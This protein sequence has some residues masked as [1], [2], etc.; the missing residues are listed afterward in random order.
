[1][2]EGLDNNDVLMYSTLNEGKLLIA[3]NYKKNSKSIQKCLSPI[4]WQK[5]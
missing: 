5:T 2:Q 3:E 1:M 4:H